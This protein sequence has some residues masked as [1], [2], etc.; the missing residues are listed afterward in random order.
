MEIRVVAKDDDGIRLDRW[1]KRHLP[2]VSHGE[3]QKA[4]RKK[5]VRVDGARAESNTTISA[6]QELKIAPFLFEVKEEA[7]KPK[8]PRGLSPEKIRETQ[9]WVIY[10]DKDILVVNKPAGLAVQGGSGVTDHLDGRLVA[11][12]ASYPTPPKLVHR[13]DRDTSGV[14]VLGRTAKAAAKL[15]DAFRHRD[16]QKTYWALVAGVPHPPEGE[17]ESKLEKAERGG[18]KEKMRMTEDGKRAITLYRTIDHLLGT[19]AWMELVPITGR[20]HQLRVHMAEL[21]CPIVGDGKYGGQNALIEGMDLAP[22]VHLHARSLQL[23]Y[24]P[25]FT[26]PLPRHMKQ[27]FKECGFVEADG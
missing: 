10:E 25:L 17:L 12:Q 26:A 18:G 16:T 3:L 27:S 5:L 8:K 20:T 23:P 13:L 15:A 6:G 2:H 19:L 24:Y 1:F 9:S 7:L 22:Q 21:G 11:L 14:M 4:L